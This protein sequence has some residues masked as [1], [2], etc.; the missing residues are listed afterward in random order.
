[1]WVP[2]GDFIYNERVS[3]TQDCEPLLKRQAQPDLRNYA[4]SWD[5]AAQLL[6]SAV[7]R[8]EWQQTGAAVREQ[9][10]KMV[11]RKLKAKEYTTS[12]PN[13]PE[14][15]YVVIQFETSFEKLENGVETVTPKFDEEDGSWKVSGYFVK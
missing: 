13:A 8:E 5:E 3:L 7:T 12:L 9:T 2:R 6:Q 15:E 11:S 14:G 4:K 1:M 10:G